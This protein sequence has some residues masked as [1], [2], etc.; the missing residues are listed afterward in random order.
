MVYSLLGEYEKAVN[1]LEKHNPNGMFSDTIGLINALNLDKTKE[2]APYLVEGVLS[3]FGTMLN[4]IL[5]YTAVLCSE[6]KFSTADKLLCIAVHMMEGLYGDEKISF[7]DKE[8]SYVYILLAYTSLKTGDRDKAIELIKRTVY[9]TKRFDSAPNY[10]IGK[11]L[12]D[13]PDEMDVVMRDILGDSAKEGIETML[14]YIK[15]PEMNKLWEKYYS[16]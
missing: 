3:G 6:N 11:F 4:S 7:A 9:H 15:D 16:S 13:L 10:S 2:A 5:G 14:K 12:F 1:I 8:Y